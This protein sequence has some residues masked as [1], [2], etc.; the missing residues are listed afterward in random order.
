MDDY[1]LPPNWS[2]I[3]Y[4]SDLAGYYNSRLKVFTWDKPF[5]LTPNELFSPEFM[6]SA[7]LRGE[8]MKSMNQPSAILTEAEKKDESESS[9]NESEESDDE[10]EEDDE[11]TEKKNK[12]NKKPKSTKKTSKNNKTTAKQDTSEV[13]DSEQSYL[14]DEKLT[15]KLLNKYPKRFV[16]D[17]ITVYEILKIYFK[18]FVFLMSE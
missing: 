2:K 17:T 3:I 10:K 7:M 5:T 12:S 6:E 8:E 9:H 1:K 16:G 11:S 13:T 4:S 15:N 18:R 14:L